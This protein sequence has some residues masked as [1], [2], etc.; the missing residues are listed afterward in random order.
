MAL[1]IARDP[2]LRPVGTLMAI[3]GVIWALFAGMALEAGTYGQPFA[4]VALIILGV[5][6][7]GAG[8][9]SEQI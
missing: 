8:K 5:L 3:V 4:S 9:P 1:G 7:A 2:V 6:V